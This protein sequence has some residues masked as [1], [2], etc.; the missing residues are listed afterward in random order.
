MRVWQPFAVQ[1]QKETIV[2]WIIFFFAKN[3]Y[4]K[5]ISVETFDESHFSMNL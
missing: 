3:K 2:C 5:Q 4:S 1:D